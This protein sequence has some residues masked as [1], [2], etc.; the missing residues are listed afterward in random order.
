[1][2]N[3][4]EDEA[5]RTI[6]AVPGNFARLTYLAS[7]QQQPGKYR[8]W[9]L[10]RE[11]GE[12]EVSRAFQHSHRVVLETVLQTDLSELLGDLKAAADERGQRV[13]EFLRHLFS[14]PLV[15]TIGL[16]RH[17]LKHFNFVLESLQS[18]ALP[19]G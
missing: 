13:S 18:L 3:S 16:P 5:F 19:R 15:R 9:G 4:V 17:S 11:Y 10:A 6:S 12:E 1:M 14:S 2:I 7:L 8:H